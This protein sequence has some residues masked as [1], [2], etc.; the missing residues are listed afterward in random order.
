MN[1]ITKEQVLQF[2]RTDRSHQ[3]GLDLYLKTAAPLPFLVRIFNLVPNPERTDKLFYE[4]AKSVGIPER[5]WRQILKTPAGAKAEK[6]KKTDTRSTRAEEA[7]RKKTLAE[8]DT[9]FQQDA[10]AA[11]GCV[12]AAEF[13]F[14]ADASTPEEIRAL[15][16]EK[17]DAWYAL[18]TA[19]ADLFK[20]VTDDQYTD[21]ARRAIASLE[22]NQDIWDELVAYRD[23]GRPL[24][25]VPQ[26]VW[27]KFKD[28]V[29]AK[30]D[31][32]LPDMLASLRSQMSQNKDN[33]DK[34]KTLTRKKEYVEAEI[35]R[36]R[37]AAAAQ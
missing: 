19:R 17:M 33:P 32:E 3:G 36:R 4:L 5:E 10:P 20:A 28:E 21:A 18:Q 37:A 25:K 24:Y 27:L 12:M 29:T 31:L 14:L 22:A 13:P 34:V 1:T 35:E 23:T 16:G 6:E 15:D 7:Q 8:I 30:T 2:F 9:A 11:Q 26:L